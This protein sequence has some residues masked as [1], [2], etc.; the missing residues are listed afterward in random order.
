M[1]PAELAAWRAHMGYSQRAAADA[2]G[3]TASTYQQ[4]ERGA[5]FRTGAPL[6]PDKRTALAC[7]A[8]AAGLEPW[9]EKVAP[10][11]GINS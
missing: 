6:Q 7:A 2:L 4:W 11:I 5:S 3:V 10:K 8:I 1:T 9:P